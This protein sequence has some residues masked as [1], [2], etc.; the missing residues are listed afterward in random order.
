M[1]RPTC[2]RLKKLLNRET[3]HAL[4]RRTRTE[5]EVV[6]CCEALLTRWLNDGRAKSRRRVGPRED[7]WSVIGKITTSSTLPSFLE[8]ALASKLRDRNATHHDLVK[9]SMRC[10]HDW[11]VRMVKL[12]GSGNVQ[13]KIREITRARILLQDPM[14]NISPMCEFYDRK[15]NQ[16]V[17]AQTSGPV[18][19][20]WPRD[21]Y[22]W[23]EASLPANGISRWVR[24]GLRPHIDTDPRT[25]LSE[26]RRRGRPSR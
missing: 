20:H 16:E 9:Q 8:A 22:E 12:W 26:P 15:K 21:W 10:P 11:W 6:E 18:S 14:A 2:V 25:P 1:K 4:K 5:Q 3:W 19:I 24:D 17:R 13:Y 7:C 23:M